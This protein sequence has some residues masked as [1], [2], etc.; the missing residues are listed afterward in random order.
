VEYSLAASILANA[1]F[2]TF[3]K[4]TDKSH[5]TLQNINFAS[6]FKTL[7]TS[8]AQKAKLR[9]VLHYFDWMENLDNRKGS[10]KIYRQVR[11]STILL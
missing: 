1:F 5:P 4:R 6:F 3:P 8:P 11:N 10:F 2:S 9:S 7:Q